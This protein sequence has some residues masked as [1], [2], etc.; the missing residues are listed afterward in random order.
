[1]DL[2][3]AFLT[4]IYHDAL[5]DARYLVNSFVCPNSARFDDVDA[6]SVALLSP[7]G[8]SVETTRW[9]LDVGCDPFVENGN[10]VCAALIA[11][12]D[13]QICC[14]IVDLIVAAARND[15]GKQARLVRYCAT[16]RRRDIM[17]ALRSFAV[18]DDVL[19]RIT[20]AHCALKLEM[21]GWS[22]SDMQS[23]QMCDGNA[24]S[25]TGAPI[26]A[27]AFVG[28]RAPFILR[29]EFV[30]VR[31][32]RGRTPL[33]Y[34]IDGR[35]DIDFIRFLCRDVGADVNATS[36][37][38]GG[39]L[40]HAC[41]SGSSALVEEILCTPGFVME[42]CPFA[43]HTAFAFF[44]G[45]MRA[46][47]SLI[48]AG[49]DVLAPSAQHGWPAI[50]YLAD[51]IARDLSRQPGRGDVLKKRLELVSFAL[52]AHA[53]AGDEDVRCASGETFLMLA[54]AR[55]VADLVRRALD[56]HPSPRKLAALVDSRGRTAYHWACARC[57]KDALKCLH[58]Y[59][60][61]DRSA[62]AAVDADGATGANLLL[63]DDIISAAKYRDWPI[64]LSA[65]DALGLDRDADVAAS[66]AASHARCVAA[67]DVDAGLARKPRTC[68]ACYGLTIAPKRCARCKVE[69]YCSLAC[70]RVAWPEHR[71]ACVNASPTLADVLARTPT[72]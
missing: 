48:A 25:R 70:Q 44:D 42:K 57:S 6:L 11:C 63:A 68:A 23:L 39:V 52:D 9:L 1:M 61:L 28:N 33:M 15:S 59:D 43:L 71:V 31:D 37:C 60:L 67:F 38:S 40:E 24:G 20:H 69:V 58:E 8:T 49:Y 12:A 27:A 22:D 19:R 54:C 62:R 50:F 56:L 64:P 21:N 4:A 29:P 47:K 51:V 3:R 41:R 66:V 34:A 46:I 36:E 72:A 7:R 53:R 14:E 30:N 13:A 2:N 35:C 45:D 16:F 55:D 65:A 5:E 18:D 32:E 17:D 10:G 26:H